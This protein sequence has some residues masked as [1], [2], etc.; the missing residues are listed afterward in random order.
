MPP[1]LGMYVNTLPATINCLIAS[2]AG[3]RTAFASINCA[4][5]RSIRAKASSACPR[6]SSP[7]S[8]CRSKSSIVKRKNGALGGNSVI[9]SLDA[10]LLTPR[11]ATELYG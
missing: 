3:T 11:A 1:S 10:K 8:S 9:N 4:A 6:A 2:C 5:D 7:A